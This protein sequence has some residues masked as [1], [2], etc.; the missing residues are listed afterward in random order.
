M[1]LAGFS[2]SAPVACGGGSVG[3]LFAE[4]DRALAMALYS[5]GPLIGALASRKEGARTDTY[6]HR[7]YRWTGGWRLHCAGNRNQ[8]GLH[9]YC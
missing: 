5:L 6:I 9:R 8:V 7:P 4:K 1:F 2:G 3:D